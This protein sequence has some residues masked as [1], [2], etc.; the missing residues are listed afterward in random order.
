MKLLWILLL[1][2]ALSACATHS[3]RMDEVHQLVRGGD[4]AQAQVLT[5]ELLDADRDRLLRLM[6]VGVLSYL[7][8]DF[9]ASIQQLDEADRLADDLY[10]RS[11]SDLM[12]RLSTNASRTVYRGSLYERVYI[13]Y[14]KTLAFLGLAETATSA[15]QLERYLEAAR[16]EGRRAQILL[17]ETRAREGD[18][19]E[20]ERDNERTL[21]QMMNFFRRLNGDVIHPSELT[22]RDNAFTHYLIGTLYER[23]GELDNAR[24]SYERAAQT[25]AQ[26]Y[27]GQYDLSE[28]M[29]SQAWLDTAR[30][31]KQQGDRRWQRLAEDE[32]NATQQKQLADWNPG[33]LAQLLVIQEIDLIQPRGELNLWMRINPES[34]RLIIRPLL[35][36]DSRQQ[37][38]QL[39]WF[40]YLYADRG[41]L[42]AV[43]RLAIED[44]F[45]LITRHY[46]R[47]FPLGPLRSQLDALGLTEILAT[48]GVRL[49]VPL[50]YYWEPSIQASELGINQASPQP[51]Q[52]ADNLGG[53]AMAQHLL[54]ARQEMNQAMAVESLRLLLCVQTGVPPGLCALA[55]SSTVTADT[56]LWS[57]L[58]SEV[59]ISR[60]ILEP[61]EHQVTLTTQ[62]PGQPNS[63]TRSFRLEAGDL[64]IWRTRHFIHED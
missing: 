28:G 62:G 46:E 30:I 21:V 44:Y 27:A 10:T 56:R 24:V 49:A 59:K 64:K 29:A 14:Y 51:L 9:E 39:A 32:L 11:L 40:H 22:F 26:G 4:Y 17:D 37:A 60:Q 41:L 50:F 52:R 31:L 55:T 53:L 58:P 15:A 23:F 47:S 48:T 1:L 63:E 61:G 36:G 8:G 34:N 6:E 3:E 7:Q 38:Y 5:E 42:R 12:T 2:A 20:A 35:T 16:I 43:E 19:Q 57:L 33:Q 18:Y 25:Y 54:D 13:H 45:G